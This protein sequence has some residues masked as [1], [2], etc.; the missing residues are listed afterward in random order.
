MVRSSKLYQVARAAY[1]QRHMDLHTGSA[2]V[3]GSG[4]PGYRRSAAV[5]AFASAALLT[6]V[7]QLAIGPRLI[8]PAFEGVDYFAMAGG[9]HGV[10]RFY[11]AGRILHPFVVGAFAAATHLPLSL[12]F[13]IANVLALFVFLF[14]VFEYVL[15]AEVHRDWGQ[16]F[17]LA[18]IVVTAALVAPI[19]HF[20]IQDIFYAAL[21][22]VFFLLFRGNVYWGLAVLFAL[23]L[24][25]ESTIVLTFALVAAALIKNRRMLAALTAVV[26]A[27]GWATSA[28]FVTVGNKHGLSTALFDLLKIGYNFAQNILGM[29]IW[30]DTNAATTH[31]SPTWTMPV[32]RSWHL[33]AVQQIGFCG[34]EPRYVLHTWLVMVCAFGILPI[35]FL[36]SLRPHLW[37]KLR[38]ADHPT[39]VAIVY[40]A[41]TFLMV[42]LIGTNG[43][44]ERYVLYA[45]PIFVFGTLPVLRRI[46]SQDPQRAAELCYLNLVCSWAPVAASVWDVGWKPA[47]VLVLLLAALGYGLAY[48]LTQ[49]VTGELVATP[50]ARGSRRAAEGGEVTTEA[51][52]GN[53]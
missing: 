21:L 44:L 7:L 3:D 40:G 12:V 33:G 41:L 46:A 16:T 28:H 48:H 29:V 20:Y 45:W 39:L 51:P 9:A 5:L 15:G 6:L 32:A 17:R 25:R 14:V 10:A 43:T 8:G 26:G 52:G 36:R 11:Y 37:L 38:Y 49:G 42:P 30:T 22:A 24:T 50:R 31:C 2:P 1:L 47:I 27:G 19:K 18:S 4:H 53:R 23:H 35:V 34:F 13:Y